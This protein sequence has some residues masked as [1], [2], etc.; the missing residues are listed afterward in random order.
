MS[1][2]IKIMISILIALTIAGI[3]TIIIL[4]YADQDPLSSEERSIDDMV[5]NSF[6][7][8]EIRTD[9]ADGNFVLI[10]FRI[11]ANSDDAVEYLQKGEHFQINNVILKELTVL[12]EENFRSGLT[13]IE[14]Q[15]KDRLNELLDDQGED[16]ENQG[17]VTDVF[18]IDKVLQ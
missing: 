8:E 6:V 10:Q 16:S 13:E 9:L 18:I 14:E 3:A 15:I 2:P 11:V 5:E 1:K 12:E 7:T 17:E 4:I